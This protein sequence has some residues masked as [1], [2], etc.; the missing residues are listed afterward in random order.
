MSRALRMGIGLVSLIPV[1]GIAGGVLVA[2]GVE[3]A[4]VGWLALAV[5]VAWF[6]LMAWWALRVPPKPG[7]EDR[8]WGVFRH[9]RS[10]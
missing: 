9:T 8:T 1:M 10:R 3:G 4:A 7:S 6:A 2:I 5:G